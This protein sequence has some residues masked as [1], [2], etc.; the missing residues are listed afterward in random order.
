MANSMTGFGR[1]E[2]IF[3]TRRYSVELKSVNSRFCDI[4]IRMPKLFNYADARIRKLISD[5]LVRGKVDVFINYEDFSEGSSEV[6]INEGLAKAY[7]DAL[8]KIAEV[9][10]RPDDSNSSRISSFPDVL[11]TRQAQIDEDTIWGELEQTALGAIEGM[12]Q[13]R[14]VEGQNLA[15]DI[16]GKIDELAVIRNEIDERA[17]QVVVEYRQRL[18]ERIDDL[19]TDASRA[20]YDEARFAAEVAIF[21]DKCAIDEELKRLESHFSQG[22]SILANDDQVGKKMDFLIQEINRETNTIGSKA[23]DLEITNRVLLMKNIIEQMREQI[24]NLV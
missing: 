19:L 7:S 17:P 3:G 11:V 4:S 10:G 14:S 5:S 1:C 6:V 18:T 2:K 24:Q 13:M 22:R 8:L 23:N 20:F 9:T 16:I 12:Q 15:A 21:T